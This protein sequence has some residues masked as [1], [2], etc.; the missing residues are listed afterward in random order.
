MTYIKNILI[1]TILLASINNMLAQS[2]QEITFNI[3]EKDVFINPITLDDNVEEL[4][5]YKNMPTQFVDFT[6]KY[7]YIDPVQGVY[8]KLMLETNQLERWQKFKSRFSIPDTLKIYPK[9]LLNSK[10]AVF[11]ALDT[12]Q[13]VIM[14]VD[15]N[16][17]MDL[18]DDE[19]YTIAKS[20]IPN[21]KISLDIPVK[22]YNA[23]T[24]SIKDSVVNLEMMPVLN[25]NT[26]NS[27]K[28]LMVKFNNRK[29]LSAEINTK[30]LRY[31]LSWIPLLSQ[32]RR[33]TSSILPIRLNV[34]NKNNKV[35]KSTLHLA[36]DTVV[37]DNY[38]TIIRQYDNNH[39]IFETGS[40]ETYGYGVGQIFK[41]SSG[42]DIFNLNK[43]I[44]I[45][46]KRYLVLDFW[47][48]WCAP[49]I[50]AMPDL[51]SFEQKFKEKADVISVVFDEKSKIELAKK[52]INE[53]KLT[54]PQIWEDKINPSLTKL[55]QIQFFPTLILINKEQKIVCV[56]SDI[57][58]LRDFLEKL[59]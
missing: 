24:N 45:S 4:N 18:S 7:L 34:I 10:L 59:D 29:N 43:K 8:E 13:N 35:I 25:A 39:L 49:C 41:P 33:F 1:L 14:I 16:G 37:I 28:D 11:Y 52:L 40:K 56:T 30:E 5:I 38:R 48:T 58:E 32:N 47:G 54:W 46:S 44:E 53:N 27:S 50:A 36:G 21:R 51:V 15:K 3:T 23:R 2:I 17:N 12:N 57:K 31:V 42:I 19:V 6:F 22:L 55:L 20:E 9:K 26:L